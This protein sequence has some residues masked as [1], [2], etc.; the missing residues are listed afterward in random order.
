MVRRSTAPSN[1]SVVCG[2]RRRSKEA[3]H[4]P[5]DN[6][7]RCRGNR[8]FQLAGIGT[9]LSSVDE[10]LKRMKRDINE[11]LQNL[12][13]E[14]ASIRSDVSEIEGHVDPNRGNYEDVDEGE[15]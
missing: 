11:R 14:L 8:D 4:E 3:G 12:T 5:A 10:T 6:R 9:A 7:H 15:D 13:S 2:S 1:A